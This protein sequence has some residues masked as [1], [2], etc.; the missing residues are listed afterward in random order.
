MAEAPDNSR[1]VEDTLP[2]SLACV[3]TNIPQRHQLVRNSFCLCLS[4]FPFHSIHQS[5]AQPAFLACLRALSLS[6]FYLFLGA[7]VSSGSFGIITLYLSTSA[8]NTAAGNGD[9]TE[10][11]LSVPF[12]SCFCPAASF[13]YLFYFI[14]SLSPFFHPFS[15]LNMGWTFPE[16][17]LS[18]SLL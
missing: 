11:T 2:I 4:H 8:G 5:E 12:I 10:V 14:I 7:Q 6:L 18:L 3:R 15:A 1:R 16:L 17:L 13:L 9:G